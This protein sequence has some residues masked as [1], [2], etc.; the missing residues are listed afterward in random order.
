MKNLDMTIFDHNSIAFSTKFVK[1]GEEEHHN[2]T[3]MLKKVQ[4]SRKS[5]TR[6]MMMFYCIHDSLVIKVWRKSVE[7]AVR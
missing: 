6:T 5:L 1:N 4:N 3:Y 2:E 7:G